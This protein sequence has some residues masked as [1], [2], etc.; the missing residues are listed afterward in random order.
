MFELC[1]ALTTSVV[2]RPRAARARGSTSTFTWRW[3][4][5]KGAGV[6]SPGTVKSRMRMK[7]TP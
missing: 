3:R 6:E 2:E 4:P 7:F 5:P 1:R